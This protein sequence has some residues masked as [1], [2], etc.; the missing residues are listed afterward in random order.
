[1]HGAGNRTRENIL[2]AAERLFAERGVMAVSMR[3]IRIASGAKNTAAVQFH[4]GNRDGLVE[5]LIGRH[6]PDIGARQQELAAAAR[7]GDTRALVNVLARPIVEYLERGPSEAA[8]VK[9]MAELSSL[10]NL[11]LAEMFAITP[12]AGRTA[13]AA[14]HEHVERIV[15]R[16]VARERIIMM[17]E[18]SVHLCG[19]YARLIQEPRSRPHLEP[20]AFADNLVDMLH[21]ALLAPASHEDEVAALPD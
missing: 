4:F 16:S 14:L 21:A 12:E 6:M 5:A 15:P 9:I 7:P 1:V 19:V 2:D 20:D 11:Q 10:P 13:A 8:W 3:E 17:A 18:M